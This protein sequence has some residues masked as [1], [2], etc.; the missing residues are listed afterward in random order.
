MQLPL[1]VLSED[2]D[3]ER[4]LEASFLRPPLKSKLTKVL[5]RCRVLFSSESDAFCFFS[6]CWL[7]STIGEEHKVV[8]AAL[9]FYKYIQII[10]ADSH[11]T[12][13]GGLALGPADWPARPA[14]SQQQGRLGGL[15]LPFGLLCTD[16]RVFKQS[17]WAQAA[18]G[19]CSR[20]LRR[21]VGLDG[22]LGPLWLSAEPMKNHDQVRVQG[23]VA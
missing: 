16:Q 19:V 7:I 1:P 13:N 18:S 8:Y 23:P 2:G 14:Q 5:E 20:P 4:P 15:F 10:D 6:F 11:V 17:G 3:L 22:G 9:S 21:E 12:C